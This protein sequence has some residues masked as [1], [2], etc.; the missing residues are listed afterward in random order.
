MQGTPQ[1][2]Q[3]DLEYGEGTAATTQ[4]ASTTNNTLNFWL[5]VGYDCNDL[6]TVDG[7][8]LRVVTSSNQ[9]VSSVILTHIGTAATEIF[10][11]PVVKFV[12]P[13]GGWLRSTKT[14]TNRYQFISFPNLGALKGYI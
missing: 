7:D 13:P 14:T 9:V 8:Y 12:I 11:A 10:L 6:F 1:Q 5:V 2:N 4:A 3:L